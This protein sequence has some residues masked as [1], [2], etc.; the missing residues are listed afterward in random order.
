MILKI[1]LSIILSLTLTGQALAGNCDCSR[2]VAAC[3][4]QGRLEG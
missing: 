3:S 4:A 1:A 2:H